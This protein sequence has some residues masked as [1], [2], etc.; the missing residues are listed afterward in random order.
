MA[1]YRQYATSVVSLFPRLQQ[2]GSNLSPSPW[3]HR[4]KGQRHEVLCTL[5]K[6]LNVSYDTFGGVRLT[7]LDC[8]SLEIQNW[9]MSAGIY[10]ISCALNCHR[11]CCGIGNKWLSMSSNSRIPNFFTWYQHECIYQYIPHSLYPTPRCPAP[12]HPPPPNPTFQT[13]LPDPVDH[14]GLGRWGEH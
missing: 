12:P 13:P 10:L 9:D 1:D 5:R 8:R 6:I 7:I 4:S 3:F 14:M 2:A 11:F